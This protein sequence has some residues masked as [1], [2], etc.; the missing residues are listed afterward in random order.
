MNQTQLSHSW[1]HLQ[2]CFCCFPNGWVGF[3]ICRFLSSS[4][5]YCILKQ[6]IESVQTECFKYTLMARSFQGMVQNPQ[7]SNPMGFFHL[8]RFSCFSHFRS[9][10]CEGSSSSHTGL[11][12]AGRN[13]DRSS[14][15][16]SACLG[17]QD[18]RLK[19]WFSQPKI[20]T[21]RPG[22]DFGSM[23]VILINMQLKGLGS[24]M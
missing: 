12:T 13:T 5:A 2:S 15:R 4:V 17:S 7:C 20:S 18:L 23:K 21:L 8:D 3:A 16:D 11:T 19:G 10:L 14:K 9:R 1:V 24:G 22:T 6:G